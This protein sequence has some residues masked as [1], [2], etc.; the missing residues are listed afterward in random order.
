MNKIKIFLLAISMVFAN[1]A[2]A[3]TIKI[4]VNAL[5][6]EP[7]RFALAMKP[8]MEKDGYTVSI[9]A[10]P[11]KEFLGVI[12]QFA[13]DKEPSISI[14][15][16]T[17]LAKHIKEKK[18]NKED[19][20]KGFVVSHNT[21]ALTCKKPCKYKSFE[22]VLGN[23]DSKIKIG[24]STPLSR[25]IGQAIKESGAKAILVPYNGW[26]EASTD[27]MSNSID[28]FSGL[29]TNR[30]NDNIEFITIPDKYGIRTTTWMAMSYKNIPDDKVQKWYNDEYFVAQALIT[31]K[32]KTSNYLKTL[33][34]EIQK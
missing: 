29:L 7:H 32:V 18:A 16:G 25:D 19:F 13:R 31:S 33:N 27:L 20:S 14:F 21:I 17:S 2:N 22:D 34:E 5:S 15:S 11:G 4:Y 10:A 12:N 9:Q 6:S 3:E 30:K 1:L 8:A 26:S 28:L 24:V 23:T